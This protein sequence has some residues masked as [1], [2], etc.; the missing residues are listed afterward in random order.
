VSKYTVITVTAARQT[1]LF[2]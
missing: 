1:D 2:K